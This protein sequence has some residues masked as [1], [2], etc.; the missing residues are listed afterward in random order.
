M[1]N[2]DLEASAEEEEEEG[3]SYVSSRISCSVFLVNVTQVIYSCIYRMGHFVVRLMI[4]N[5]SFLLFLV[6]NY[7]YFLLPV[8]KSNIFGF[9]ECL[10]SFSDG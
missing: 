3:E 8:L 6:H 5:T 9:V 7:E 4:S 10:K 2:Q 1:Y